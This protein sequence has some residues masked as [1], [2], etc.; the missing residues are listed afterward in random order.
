MS[1]PRI[2]E[3]QMTTGRR[4]LKPKAFPTSGYINNTM[5]KTIERH[6]VDVFLAIKLI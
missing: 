3:S 5:F 2:S 1:Q 4:F 6:N